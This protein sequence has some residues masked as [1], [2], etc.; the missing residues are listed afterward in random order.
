MVREVKSIDNRGEVAPAL[1]TS[2][3]RR[4]SRCFTLEP[5]I[6]EEPQ[7][8]QGFYKGVFVSLPLLFSGFLYI[9]LYRGL[10]MWKNFTSNI[11]DIF[12]LIKVKIPLSQARESCKMKLY[13]CES[14]RNK[15]HAFSM[16]F[17]L[18]DIT[19]YQKKKKKHAFSFSN[20]HFSIENILLIITCKVKISC[21]N[22]NNHRNCTG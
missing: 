5:I 21:L 17:Q 10:L 6:E 2:H 18:N 16:H 11:G 3:Y 14:F 7:V 9:F 8:S 4:P 19:I 13:R 12:L 20:E 22:S 15:K 1:L